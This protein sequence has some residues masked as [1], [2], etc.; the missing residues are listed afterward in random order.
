MN[1]DRLSLHERDSRAPKRI[2]RTLGRLRC[3]GARRNIGSIGTRSKLGP[4]FN[5]RN[6]IPLP[7]AIAA[8]TV[9]RVGGSLLCM[10]APDMAHRTASFPIYRGVLR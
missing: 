9:A 1:P 5:A 8:G 4:M 3:H 10:E 7:P 6:I 2:E